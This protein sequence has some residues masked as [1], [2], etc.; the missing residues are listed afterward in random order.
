MADDQRETLAFLADPAL[1]G[2]RA[3]VRRVD[4]HISAVFLAG[5]RALK[6]KR[7][8]SLGY[9]DFSTLARR[10]AAVAAELAVNRRTAPALYLGAASVRRVA[11]G[12]LA[13]GPVVE[14]EDMAAD[15]A[16]IV[17]WVVVMRRFD[18]ETLFDRLAA[19]GA[20]TPDL[21]RRAAA[22]VAAFHAG[23]RRIP[24]GD[25]AARVLRVIEGNVAS[26]RR[27]AVPR[28]LAPARA[29]ALVAASRGLHA[30]QAALLDARAAGG[31]VRDG[32]GDLHLGNLCLVD[33]APTLFDAIEFDPA[34][35]EI[36]TAYDAAFLFMDLARRATAAAANAAFNAYL[37][38]SGDDGGI[39]LLPL[40]QAMRATIRGHVLATQA[41]ARTG[42]AAD[43]A[44]AESGLY[45][46]FAERA[47][48]PPPPPRLIAIGGLSGTGK[49]TVAAG[50]APGLGHPPG[51]VLLR[52]DV[53]RKALA[54]VAPTVRLGPEHYTAERTAA[55]YAAMLERAGRVL[56]AGGACIADA[57]SG[58]PAHRQALAALAARH[59]AGF[60]G[61][62][63]DAPQ[64]VRL[65]RVSAR[66][67]D[68][69]DATMDVAAA[70][71]EPEAL[72][73]PVIDAAGEPAA[74][75]A[76]VAAAIG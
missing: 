1:H 32:H 39:A 49:S 13:L 45:F 74:V 31:F 9:V 70:Q 68:A 64:A 61:V 5:Q 26:V 14:P 30:R 25:G 24:G 19:A 4:T 56:G 21:A 6:L 35:R 15:D 62:W 38:A 16:G 41:A 8:V 52:S 50:L 17:D 36:D 10:R 59:G 11:A 72:D 12:R 51:A 48:A 60:A 43:S 28:P 69:S 34:L 73:W 57:V 42:P 23:A 65:A 37:E 71:R 3:P 27:A 22:A 46:A 40:F 33:G 66:R 44:F 63:L 47:S 20:L 58:H 53:I 75:L 18:E 54:G 2:G 7:A 55:V 76:R 29:E 67:N